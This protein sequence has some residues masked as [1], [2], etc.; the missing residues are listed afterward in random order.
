MIDLEKFRELNSGMVNSLFQLIQ[1]ELEQTSE[2]QRQLL[3]AFGFGMIYAD[4]QIQG[5]SPV[6]VHG[7]AIS[8]LQDVFNYSSEQAGEFSGFLVE[9]ASDRSVHSTIH[10]IIHRGITG[11]SQWE[12]KKSSELKANIDEILKEVEKN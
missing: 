7:L 11:H 6:Q 1:V 2:L 9:V 5:L 10:A 3:A 12:Q 4:G 8:M